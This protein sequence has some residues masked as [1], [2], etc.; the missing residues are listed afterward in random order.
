LAHEN[1]YSFSARYAT[2]DDPSA[3]AAEDVAEAVRKFLKRC[4]FKPYPISTQTPHVAD[5]ET[6]RR[7]ICQLGV[8]G[9][10]QVLDALKP[11]TWVVGDYLQWVRSK[12]A[13]LSWHYALRYPKRLV[14]S[15]ARHWELVGTWVVAGV[16]RLCNPSALVVATRH[17]KVGTY[18]AWLKETLPPAVFRR[19]LCVGEAQV[20]C[21]KQPCG[22]SSRAPK[23]R[24]CSEPLGTLLRKP[25]GGQ[26][27]FRYGESWSMIFLP[28]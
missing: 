1:G 16:Q 22:G 21:T 12:T 9:E 13:P 14:A 24:S 28:L 25:H 27:L 23:M 17:P 15:E 19:T 11:T 6:L 7:R 20:P 5:W 2:P 26:V 10:R 18:K 4:P 8:R 3:E